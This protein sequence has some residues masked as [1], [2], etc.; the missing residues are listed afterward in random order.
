MTTFRSLRPEP[1]LA[2]PLLVALLMQLLG[3]V[4]RLMEQNGLIAHSLLS[5]YSLPALGTAACTLML[6]TAVSRVLNWQH[7]RQLAQQALL[8]ERATREQVLERAV[9]ER[10]QELAMASSHAQASDQ[11]KSRLLASLSHDLRAP[12]GVMV[13]V[14][15]SM[16][17]AGEMQAEQYRR[18]IER[19]AHEQLLLIDELVEYAREGQTQ[20]A[21]E[22]QP[23]ANYMHG[24]CANVQAQAQTL[25][26]INNNQFELRVDAALPSVAVFDS[27]RL[28][29]VLVNLI[30]NAAKF[31]HSGRIC[32]ALSQPRPTTLTVSVSDNG[33]GI[34]TQELSQL[35]KPFFRGDNARNLQGSGLG[36]AI[37]QQIVQAMGGQLEVTSEVGQGSCFYFTIEWNGTTENQIEMP[38]VQTNALMGD[39]AIRGKS[40]LLID[41]NT[42]TREW[43]GEILLGLELELE[44]AD[45]LVQATGKCK[46]RHFDLIIC[47]QDFETGTLS[48]WVNAL[49]NRQGQQAHLNTPILLYL[50]RATG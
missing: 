46:A 9:Q 37:A 26:A 38:A 43:L 29:Q 10:T 2:R 49:H 23:A 19:H 32:L 12:W 31:T 45:H 33:Q 3:L 35:F 40:V 34:P 11:A 14:A 7:E 36:L 24:F 28:R 27:K 20:L 47:E 48:S 15:R 17:G 42:A 16:R 4:P 18:Q 39:E 22:L 6:A 25:A 13:H 1:A 21:L 41:P 44:S 30:S 5:E 50:A 8:N